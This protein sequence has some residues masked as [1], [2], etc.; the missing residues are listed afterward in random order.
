MT[1]KTT[2]EPDTL[3]LV[4]KTQQA[5][6]E[7]GNEVAAT[8]KTLTQAE[9]K[10]LATC[11]KTIE[12]AELAFVQKVLAIATIFVEKL[13]I[14]NYRSMNEYLG[15]RWDMKPSMASHHLN[16]V[17]VIQALQGAGITEKQLPQNE[18]QTRMLAKLLVKKDGVTDGSKVVKVWQ[19]ILAKG[20]KPTAAMIEADDLFPKK[21]VPAVRKT[22]IRRSM[23]K[24]I[25]IAFK[26]TKDDATDLAA[27]IGATPKEQDGL[28]VLETPESDA[29]EAVTAKV[30]NWLSDHNDV[31]QFHFSF[32]R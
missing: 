4:N 6:G 16:A 32:V 29:L 23:A 28:V 18:G 26:G 30:L 5:I 9:Q 1:V 25:S 10:K 7:A 3:K 17:A 15:N 22:P 21:R 14:A 31:E 27:Q 2:G 11:E 12:K 19:N 20:E 24:G 13:F 8:A